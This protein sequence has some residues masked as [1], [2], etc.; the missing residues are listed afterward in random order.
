MVFLTL[1][2]ILGYPWTGRE[3]KTAW[4]IG[5]RYKGVAFDIAHRKFGL[6][7]DASTVDEH[8]LA[9]EML[10]RLNRAARITDRL[11]QPLVKAQIASGNVTIQNRFHL[12]HARYQ[13][14]RVQATSAFQATHPKDGS[15]QDLTQILEKLSFETGRDREGFFYSQAML[16]AYFS[17]LEH[18]LTLLLPFAGFAVSTDSLLAFMSS[19]WTTKFNRILLPEQ[20]PDAKRWY[21]ALREIKERVRNT[22]AHGG[23]EK[24]GASLFV[25]LPFVG[26]TPV[27]LSEYTKSVN[28]DLIPLRS[29]GHFAILETLDGFDEYLKSRF[30]SGLRIIAAGLDI[31]FDARALHEYA[32]AM[33]SDQSTTDFIERE[34]YLHDRHA[35]MDY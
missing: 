12:F 20:H 4:T 31:Y 16:D 23:F 24:E 26:A 3:E 18:L 25:H 29:T 10:S 8:A 13:F 7:V 15:L 21:S 1:V 33:T 35:N 2:T 5:V 6:R 17:Q 30:N 22:F 28:Y 34:S 32:N 11:L 19:D 27:T 9:G 14:F